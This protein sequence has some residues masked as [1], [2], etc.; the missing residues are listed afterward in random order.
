MIRAALDANPRLASSLVPG[1]VLVRPTRP[2]RV[3][4]AGNLSV[5]R[6]ARTAAIRRHA[7]ETMS[8]IR[9]IRSDHPGIS[10][11]GLY[12]EL[13]KAR[14]LTFNKQAWTVSRVQR[15]LETYD[16]DQSPAP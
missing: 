14:H 8:I 16:D 11:A 15:F 1:W 9:G 2:K 6:A 10:V 4:S 5:A 3:A 7:T 13:N 12:Y